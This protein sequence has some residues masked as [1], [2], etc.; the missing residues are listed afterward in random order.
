[1]AGGDEGWGR[2]VLLEHERLNRKHTQISLENKDN[3]SF[4]TTTRQTQMH[5]DV[6]RGV[7][8]NTGSFVRG[9]GSPDTR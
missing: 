3:E 2:G 9:L 7:Q 6:Q 1:M 8:I 5:R 4:Q